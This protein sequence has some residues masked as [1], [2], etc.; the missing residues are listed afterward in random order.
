MNT[1]SINLNFNEK[2]VFD[3]RALYSL[4]GYS[5]YKMS[6][7]EE[8]DLYA[9]NKDFLISDS[10]ITFT[11][12]NGKLMALKP[13]VTLSIVKNT[14]D[15][16]KNTEKVYYNENVY[17]ISKGTN[18][19]KEIMQIG[20]ECI[21]NIDNYNISEVITLACKSLKSISNNS[22]LD[23]SHLGIIT[24]LMD[25]FSIPS[26]AKSEM[27]KYIGEKNLHEL[28]KLCS[29]L[30]LSY[31]NTE[32]LKTIATTSGKTEELLPILSEKLNNIIDTKII[33]DLSLILSSLDNDIKE[34]IR[35]DFS[36]VSDTH[37]YNA[38]VFKGFIE[39]IPT[40]VLSGG[41]YDKLM[42]K[43]KRKS[44]AIGFAVYLDMLD[45]LDNSTNEYDVDVALLYNSDSE[46][47]KLNSVIN[48]LTTEGKSVYACQ[49]LPESIKYREILNINDCEVD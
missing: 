17:R 1:N 28:I 14:K 31:E 7:F 49:S 8:Y 5:Q 2:V 12:T 42:L 25:A 35:L 30:D 45:M 13:D 18:T 22:V 41:Q 43:M 27:I 3:L 34:M 26:Y 21:G 19:Y 20:L 37:Y 9:R 29:E 48:E 38:I 36:V 39:G 6:K 10:V 16:N 11:D 15:N 46:L 4:R 23:I 33:D 44:G 47:H 32:L 24:E 40:S